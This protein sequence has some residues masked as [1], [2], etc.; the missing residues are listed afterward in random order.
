VLYK[1]NL[2]K[3]RVFRRPTFTEPVVDC[4]STSPSNFRPLWNRSS[5][6][7]NPQLDTSRLIRCLP[8]LRSPFDV[9]RLII[10][11][12]V[13]AI[14]GVFGRW[15]WPDIRKE[16]FKRVEP[17][18]TNFDP[19]TSIS[20]VIMALAVVAPRFHIAPR[21]MLGASRHTMSSQAGSPPTAARHNTSTYQIVSAYYSV[22]A[23]IA[24]TFIPSCRV[25]RRPYRF[26]FTKNHDSPKPTARTNRCVP[27]P[28]VLCYLTFNHVV[29]TSIRDEMV[30]VRASLARCS[31]LFALY[32][33]PVKGVGILCPTAGINV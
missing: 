6:L 16:G 30:R 5:I 23:T 27:L 32:T 2:S 14:N 29:T 13:N 21:M 18:A 24:K 9:S 28:C 11:I 26:K 8:L 1:S 31:D 4:H 17:A 3:H 15:A 22:F 7:S 20:F 10:T 25:A 33:I 12:I 19:S